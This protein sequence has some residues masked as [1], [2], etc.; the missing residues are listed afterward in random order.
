MRKS[1]LVLLLA[2]AVVMVA[3]TAKADTTYNLTIDHCTGGCGTS[4]LNHGA[5]VLLQNQGGGSV[6][7][8][9]T[10]NNGNKFV[11]TG[12]GLQN[13]FDFNL[14][15]ISSVTGISVA[16]TGF[17]SAGNTAGSYHFDGFGD[18]MYSI[19]WGSQGGGNASN[20]N[21]LVFTVTAVGLTE[22]SFA[23]NSAGGA[24]STFFGADVLSGTTGNTGPIGGGT[25]TP[26]PEPA[27]LALFSAGL[28]GLGGLIRRRK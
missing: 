9:V 16:T 10:L 15:G 2:A 23:Q 28:V 6:K 18:F 24:P 12:A 4:A 26:T 8:T 27:S 22:G 14:N 7:V 20:S 3:P 21:P 1:L 11:N 13:A 17:S 25:L 5:T 19:V